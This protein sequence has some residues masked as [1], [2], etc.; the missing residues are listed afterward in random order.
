MQNG[1]SN[2]PGHGRSGGMG[3]CSVFAESSEQ[4]VCVCGGDN[5]FHLA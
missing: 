1:S 4:N 5:A 2:I 3:L